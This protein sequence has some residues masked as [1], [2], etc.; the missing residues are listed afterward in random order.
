[1]NKEELDGL[2]YKDF[3]IKE[4]AKILNCSPTNIRYW[5][6]KFSIKRRNKKNLRSDE[7]VKMNLKRWKRLIDHE[8]DYNWGEIQKFYDEGKTWRDIQKE[9]SLT[10]NT[11]AKAISLNLFKSRDSQ[12]TI[13][14]FPKPRPAFSQKTKDAMSQKRKEWLSANP[15]KHPWRRHNKFKSIPCEYLKNILKNNKYV[16]LEE[17]QPLLHLGRYFAVDIAFVDKKIIIEVNGNQHYNK[18]KTLKPYYFNRNELI[19]KEGWTIYEVHYSL[20][21]NEVYISDLMKLL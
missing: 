17:M 21:Y 20:V 12:E 18:D 2:C 19:K 15:D 1:M 9:F 11:L 4:I 6:K 7:A 14:R 13:S 3:S 10:A 8:K 5:L 16:F